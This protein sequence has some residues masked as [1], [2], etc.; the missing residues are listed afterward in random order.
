MHIDMDALGKLYPDGWNDKRGSAASFK[1]SDSTYRVYQPDWSSNSSGGTAV[2]K[3]DNNVSAELDDHCTLTVKFDKGGNITNLAADWTLGGGEKLPSWSITLAADATAL[4]A[5]AIIDVLSE[6]LAVELDPI[7]SEVAADVVTAIGKCYNHFADKLAA[8]YD[9]GGQ[10][11]FIAVTNHNLNKLCASLVNTSPAIPSSGV[12]LHFSKTDFLAAMDAA[13]DGC[14]S[15]D[16]K[17]GD[18]VKY[19]QTYNGGD[20]DYRTWKPD[21][22]IMIGGA[23][24]YV[25]TKIDNLRDNDQD[26]HIILMAGINAAGKLIQA[27]AAVQFGEASPSHQKPASYVTDVITA[28]DG[29][30]VASALKAAM[31]ALTLRSYDESNNSRQNIPN[32]TMTNL[33]AMLKA[34]SCK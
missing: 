34:V 19:T 21:A 2:L 20:R 7:I 12:S 25:S 1:S 13:V 31:Q 22:S 10:L 5:D 9:N 24:I 8:Y 33:Q 6:G 14:S 16:D 18:A 32:V 15:W 29:T 4:A 3:Q 28:A 30:D 26:D 27:Q 17:D 23:G 11:N